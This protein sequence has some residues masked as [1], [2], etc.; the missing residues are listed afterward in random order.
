[1]AR[2]TE[3]HIDHYLKNRGNQTSVHIDQIFKTGETLTF[4]QVLIDQLL[5]QGKRH[6][7]DTIQ[8]EDE[9]E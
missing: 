3:A 8:W 9:D 2:Q 4:I 5:T 6:Y 7:D 1:M